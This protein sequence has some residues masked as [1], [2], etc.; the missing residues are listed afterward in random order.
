MNQDDKLI[1]E[2]K[3]A[4]ESVRHLEKTIWSSIG[5]LSFGNV[6]SLLI[7]IDNPSKAL[8]GILLI[9]FTWIWW[10]IARRW[11]DIQHTLLL[12]L[13]H[14]ET[15]LNLYSQRYVGYRDKILSLEI[16]SKLEK[17]L[18][19]LD[20]EFL[21]ELKNK[22]HGFE[23]RGVQKWI[24][25]VPWVVTI[26]WIA[27]I[28]VNFEIFKRQVDMEKVISLN[29]ISLIVG[30]IGLLGIGVFLGFIWGKTKKWEWVN[31][32]LDIAQKAKDKEDTGRS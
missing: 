4:S 28:F 11:W 9:S 32:E 31:E 14:I 8:L 27:S 13:R 22:A 18:D 25:F 21:P 17:E 23:K 30:S 7:T 6:G 12:R 2:Y 24:R 1:E 16:E 20:P 15:L 3:T 26:I 5:L 29:L 10:G 19:L